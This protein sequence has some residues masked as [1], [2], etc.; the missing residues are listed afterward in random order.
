M[1]EPYRINDLISELIH[2]IVF[3][4]LFGLVVAVKK[5]HNL[6]ARQKLQT[7]YLKTAEENCCMCVEMIM[8]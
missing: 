6:H 1:L 3:A 8:R 5:R 2:A 7:Y 4:S